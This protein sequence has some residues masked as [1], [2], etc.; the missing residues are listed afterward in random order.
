MRYA[1]MKYENVYW[2]GEYRSPVGRLTLACDG[3]H[4]TGL[5]MEG[6]KYFGATV[7]GTMEPGANLP[8]L[9]RT[10]EWL[11]RYFAGERPAL[12]E[13]PLAPAGSPFRQAVWQLLGEIPYGQVV[14]YGALARKLAERLG[15]PT[16]SRAVG[17]VVGHNPISIIIPCHRVVG[18]NG[19]LTGYAGGVDRK[20]WLLEH[21]GT[22]ILTKSL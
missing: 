12:G 13:L 11:D 2:S 16:S 19:S 6:Q 15:R 8:I 4:L 17:G 20:R 22:A 5:W 18:S 9:A 21:E 3:E 7:S 1:G 10:R 14:T